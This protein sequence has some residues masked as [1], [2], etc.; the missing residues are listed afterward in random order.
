VHNWRITTLSTT[1]YFFGP[2]CNFK[3]QLKSCLFHV[4]T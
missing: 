1:A 3:R 2:L 4:W